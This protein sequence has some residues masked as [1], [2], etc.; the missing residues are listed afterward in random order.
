MVAENVAQ[1]LAEQ[2]PMLSEA[3]PAAVW[4]RVLVAWAGRVTVIGEH[5]EDAWKLCDT[6]S[7]A[8]VVGET[9]QPESV[10]VVAGP[11]LATVIWIMSFMFAVIEKVPELPMLF[12][13]PGYVAVIIAEA[14]GV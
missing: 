9:E 6:P 2:A 13:S 14:V 5:P 10:T 8:I 7:A 11:E 3:P 4:Y 1:E 12:T